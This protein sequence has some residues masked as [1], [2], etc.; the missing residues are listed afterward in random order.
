MFVSSHKELRVWLG[1]AWGRRVCSPLHLQPLSSTKD[2]AQS[3]STVIVEQV[4]FS[5]SCHGTRALPCHYWPL[6]FQHQG[7]LDTEHLHHPSVVKNYKGPLAKHCIVIKTPLKGSKEL[8][9]LSLTTAGKIAPVVLNPV[10]TTSLM[11]DASR[12]TDQL[13]LPQ[14]VMRL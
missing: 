12:S 3:Q 8:F 5:C 10:S 9:C 7:I 2:N 14:K 11:M 4:A 1:D 13:H 6:H